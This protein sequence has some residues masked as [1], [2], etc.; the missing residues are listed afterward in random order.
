MEER[1]EFA[2][3]E[4]LHQAIMV[5]L[6]SG[7]PDLQVLRM[8]LPK[9]LGIKSYCLIGL[10]APKQLLFKFDQYDDFVT[11]QGRQGLRQVLNE[12]RKLAYGSQKPD[13]R[14]NNKIA[15]EVIEATKNGGAD[16]VTSVATKI[17]RERLQRQILMMV[18]YEADK[19]TNGGGF[20]RPTSCGNK[21]FQVVN[22]PQAFDFWQ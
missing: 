5:E 12:K 22:V 11:A 18:D 7:A 19:Y 21:E 15:S 3:E 4:G 13:E 10:P 9:I 17:I 14:R 20:D 1:E 8:L 16:G 2:I 6:A